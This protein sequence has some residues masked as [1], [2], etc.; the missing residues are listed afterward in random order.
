MVVK[1]IRIPPT[2]DDDNRPREVQ[3]LA[4]LPKC[5]RVLPLLG[6]EMNVP[7]A[8]ECSIFL[9]YC[10]K[11][12]LRH[13]RQV[14]YEDK[15]NKPVPETCIWRLFIQLT[16]A[17]SFL[18]DGLA[19]GGETHEGW[20]PLIHRDI[21]PDNVLVV[22]NGC[23]YP[24]F[25]LA[26]FG[27]SKFYDPSRTE[28][29][30]GTYIWQPPELPRIATPMADVWS[31][32][33]AVQYLAL[34]YGPVADQAAFK[35]KMWEE[36]GTR[37]KAGIDRNWWDTHLPRK[38]THVN[39]SKEQQL[40]DG[41]NPKELNPQYSDVLDIWIRKALHMKARS[42]ISAKGLMAR[43]VPDG[44]KMIRKMAKSG[45]LT[46]MEFKCE[47]MRGESEESEDEDSSDD[48]SD[49][50]E[51]DEADFDEEDTDPSKNYHG[52]CIKV[53]PR[54]RV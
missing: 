8:G 27:C 14:E 28:S 23:T 20:V 48:G 40:A 19:A 49:E 7:T 32:G 30:C 10:P 51:E 50:M 53:T 41:A 35:R 17:I 4:F 25:K 18:H 9:E 36:W 43:M 11:G 1:V 46:D 24:S 5:N 21:K 22:F 54:F 44:L 33:A 34:G 52:R 16:Q 26:D 39:V 38:P 3:H 6:I 12:D 15:N 45:G 42:R 29:G 2:T 37:N 31:V 13:W 47:S